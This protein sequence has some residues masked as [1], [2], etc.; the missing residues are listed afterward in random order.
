MYNWKLSAFF[1]IGLILVTGVFSNAAIAVTNDGKG[2]GN[3][4]AWG[5]RAIDSTDIGTASSDCH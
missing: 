4:A 5:F 2:D 3:T 1:I